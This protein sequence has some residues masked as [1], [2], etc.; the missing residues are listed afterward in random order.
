MWGMRGREWV[1]AAGSRPMKRNDT[2]SWGSRP[3]V[4]AVFAAR[5]RGSV[6]ILA[7]AVLAILAILGVAYVSVVRIDRDSAAAIAD[8]VNY[9]QQVQGVVA[10]VQALLA[11]DLFGNKVVTRS[12]PRS[13]GTTKLWPAMFEDGE[14]WDLPAVDA[15]WRA[16][17]A[18]VQPLDPAN[19]AVSS[20]VAPRDDAWLASTEP[21]WDPIPQQTSTWPQITNLR[22]GYVYETDSSDPDYQKYVRGDG[23]FVDLL[24]WFRQT[25]NGFGNAS[26]N[27]LAAGAADGSGIIGPDDAIDQVVYHRQVADLVRNNPA[28]VFEKF[29]EAQWVDTDGDLRADARWTQLD[30][31]G[32]LYGLKWV[33]AAR[34]IDASALL[35]FNAC[36]ENGDRTAL[37]LQGGRV[38]ADV[39]PDGRTPADIDLYRFLR[40]TTLTGY[41][42]PIE[43]LR[44]EEAFGEHISEGL[45][46]EEII[47]DLRGADG[48]Y[49]DDPRLD[50]DKQNW[51]PWSG[52]NPLTRQQRFDYWRYAGSF[53][54]KA[55]TE[56]AGG[57]PDRDLIDLMSFW[58]TNHATLISKVEQ[59][60][61]GPEDT[62]YLPPINDPD[63]PGRYGPMRS[64]ESA[65]T[66][67]R[68][69]TQFGP[70]GQPQ[71]GRLRD[72]IRHHLTPVN[73][74]GPAS[75]VP[76]INRDSR[77]V[78][79]YSRN[80]ISLPDLDAR[81]GGRND[82][83]PLLA[84]ARIGLNNADVQNV[85]EA[86]AWALA[87]L[88]GN[89]SLMP[90]AANSLASSNDHYGGGPNGAARGLEQ[91]LGLAVGSG[92]GAG[93]ALMRA[94]A[95]TVNLIDAL[96]GFNGFSEGPTVAR[97]YN[98]VQLE[99]LPDDEGFEI[100]PRFAHGDIP[101]ASLPVQIVGD[102]ANGVTLAG[103]D[104]QPFLREA[105]AFS[106][107]QN[108]FS[109]D[110]GVNPI[111]GDKR[112]FLDP[113][114]DDEQLGCIVAF[115]LGNPFHES[116]DLENYD[117]I[118]GNGTITLR[119]DLSGSGAIIPAGGV[120]TVYY[121]N[122]PSNSTFDGA[123]QALLPMWEA[124][125]Q[126]HGAVLV[127]LGG[128][129][130]TVTGGSVRPVVFQDFTSGS[131]L[132]VQLVRK[133]ADFDND[134]DLDMPSDILV[135]R[136]SGPTGSA[137]WGGWKDPVNKTIPS[138]GPD[139]AAGSFR[140]T[141]WGNLVRPTENPNARGFPA[142]VVERRASNRVNAG[143]GPVYQED[144]WYTDDEP[145][146][147]PA[148]NLVEDAEDVQDANMLGE[149]KGQLAGLPSFQLFV[150]N[151]AL[152][153][154]SDLHMISAFCH[155][156]V[157]QDANAPDIT[158]AWD[159]DNV[160]VVNP[161]WTV[162]EQLG[163]DG[164]FFYDQTSQPGTGENPY[165]GT[166]DPSRYILSSAPDPL[167]VPLAIRVFDCFEAL[168]PL[169][170]L[171]QGRMNINTA[172]KKL[173]EYLPL[174]APQSAIGVA[175]QGLLQPSSN[176]DDLMA[177]YRDRTG[178]DPQTY[179]SL[180]NLRPNNAGNP[181]NSLQRGFVTAGELAIL[182]QWQ[183]NTGN[184]QS[185]AVGFMELGAD[186]QPSD[187]IPLEMWSDFPDDGTDPLEFL[188]YG[189]TDYEPVDDAEERLALYRAVSNIVSTRSDVFITWFVIRGYDPDIIESIPVEGATMSAAQTAM[190]SDE[191]LPTYE[192]RWL[193]VLDR[194]N[195]RSPVDR[196]RVLLLAE[197][198][199]ARP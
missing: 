58:G 131:S 125:M 6:I 157:H 168:D 51:L 136:M 116:I 28:G 16:N 193:C 122:G 188:A 137:F 181:V 151:R 61:D 68:F 38:G 128:S 194:S 30:S 94:A 66:S 2:M 53:V 142:Y 49:P 63:N 101:Q 138:L 52:T 57:Y 171:V 158:N 196:P 190:N 34:I 105:V 189:N 5:R 112:L 135:D 113:N 140:F 155:M 75:P 118:V 55:A 121:A 179:T 172:P 65:V 24:Q 20:R 74:A 32:D 97:F 98:N 82:D 19:A 174:V 159:V 153:H 73:G 143:G 95:L 35:N 33:V 96:D 120:T 18:A 85:F 175:G 69:G 185:S 178:L 78:S 102:V 47:E 7:L 115:E 183:P 108:V 176:R 110:P 145:G 103:L 129:A 126:G 80:K 43:L 117:I 89:E 88:A 149:E 141:S 163:S 87:P 14:Y 90:G 56:A 170:T 54:S 91:R 25:F 191:F 50:P 104:V 166:L 160:G 114:L 15:S 27:L 22:S 133:Q 164:E 150:P 100:G 182:D 144:V 29:E 31:L 41:D 197:L 132:C 59:R 169:E 111:T 72:D 64:R 8:E 83:Y 139:P 71:A 46:V 162:S 13:S 148:S 77:F 40:A 62:G 106:A 107:Y 45:G 92:A 152:S 156:Y 146:P 17:P 42:Y 60:F 84:P 195:V 186:N 130:L 180:S 1:A 154:V 123:W 3:K 93:Y 198:P 48:A 99:Q 86:F 119:F 134:G 10:E 44:L 192:S 11:A 173:F 165:L 187:H 37:A 81:A 199:S 124:E 39:W 23:R 26:I 9:E 161:W 4:G 76:V 12:V 36:L 67:R 127:P 167:T 147:G 109:N 79:V 21:R 184:P 70:L 177:N